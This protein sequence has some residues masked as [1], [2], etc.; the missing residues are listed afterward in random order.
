MT[1]KEV[2]QMALSALLDKSG[3]SH[4]LERHTLAIEALRAALAQQETK[5]VAWV[6]TLDNARPDCVT[7]FKY[8]SVAQIERNE[9]LKYTP[10]YTASSKKEWV[11]LTKEE[12]FYIYGQ[13]HEGKLCS[14]GRLVEAKLK[15]KNNG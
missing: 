12:M 11:G 2:M 1:D 9:H 14:L 3:G 15:D 4:M 13:N 7:D 6:N 8:L 5:P 10:L